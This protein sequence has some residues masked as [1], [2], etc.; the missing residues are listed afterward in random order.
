MPEPQT[1]WQ[2]RRFVWFRG[3]FDTKI[4]TGEEYQTQALERLWTMRCGDKAKGLGLAMIPS[5]YHEYDAREHAAQ[6]E[7][8]RFLALT[9]DVDS[10]DHDLATVR[11]A[12]TAFADGAAWLIYASAHARPGDMRWRIIIPLAEEQ[13]FA[14]WHDAQLAFFAHMQARGIAMDYALARAAQPVYLPNVPFVHEK[15]GTALRGEDGKP[16]YYTREGSPVDLPGL[17][18]DQGPV[19]DG[20]AA[21]ER[22][23]AADEAERDRIRREAEK[24]R[25]ARPITDHAS[26][27]EDFAATTSI[28]TMLELCGYEQSPRNP[29]DWRSP[30]QTG[31]TYATRIMGEK[32]ISLSASDAASGLGTKCAAGCFGDA[33]DLLVHYKHGGDHKAAFRALGAERR[34]ANPNVVYLDPPEWLS[35]IPLPDE[36]PE[37]EHGDAALEPDFDGYDLPDD[38]TGEDAPLVK[39][40]PFLWRDTAAIPK[41]EWLYG[42][43]LLR[44]FVSVDVAAGG[45]GKTSLKIGEALA[46]ATGRDLYDKGLPE[47]PLSVWLWNLEDPLDEIERRVHATMQRF[48]IEPSE[49]DGRFYADSGRD[50]PLVMAT[51]GPDGA[52]IV[53]P[54]VDALIAEMIERRIDVLMVDPF[55]S[56][57]AV[58][59]ND[60]NAID[61]VAREWNVVAERTGASINLVH[62]VRKGNGA[63]ATADSARGASALVG[64]A[65]SVLVY[66]RMT[67][68][69]AAKLNV[70]AHERFFY[71]RTDNDK[72]NLAPPERGVWYRMNNVDLANGDS[73]GVACPWTPPDAFDGLTARHL[74]MV[75]KAVSEGQWRENIQT[76][77]AWV[78]HAVAAAL[79]LDIEQPHTR[80]RVQ[81]LLR[82]WIE[83]GALEVVE[84]QDSKR[85]KRKFVVVGK[86]VIL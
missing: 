6:R 18:L 55:V 76:K 56:S 70:P 81:T 51:E 71:F 23:R 64:K 27:I 59:E 83:E 40:T 54:V 19:A 43:H 26:L 17:A 62:H 44:K 20:I 61:I 77:D 13:A 34:A 60:N 3:Q 57:H 66:N 85:Q 68:D 74:Y 15:S 28:E 84:D 46:M 82:T 2:T 41:R 79:E 29:L 49:L 45:V 37:W 10:G 9:G 58:S 75:Q 11:D 47:G 14:V 78:G 73:V 24:R 69:E 7:H 1:A 35:E 21:I 67:E 32:W 65:R 53:R 42:K 38:Q 12:V 31:E 39:A 16:L 8:G 4:Q 72:A 52:R 86:W 63:E 50:Q 30:Q 48:K 36:A 33:Y 25:A 80:K 5:S 22:Q